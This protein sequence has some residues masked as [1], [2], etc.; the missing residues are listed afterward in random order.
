MWPLGACR[1]TWLLYWNAGCSLD[2]T[3]SCDDTNT[4]WLVNSK[5]E[6]LNITEVKILQYRVFIVF[7]AIHFCFCFLTILTTLGSWRFNNNTLDNFGRW[8]QPCPQLLVLE[9]SPGFLT[10]WR[11]SSAAL[12]AEPLHY[13]CSPVEYSIATNGTQQNI[14][15][16]NS[17]DINTVDLLIYG[18]TVH[19]MA[20]ESRLD[21]THPVHM[22]VL[23]LLKTKIYSL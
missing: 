14:F 4:R 18:C 12:S 5:A 21:S 19:Y 7:V 1:D 13:P 16:L 23:G 10:D 8:Y 6:T 2:N 17:A 20:L 22:G 11:S 3:G 9:P 15:Y